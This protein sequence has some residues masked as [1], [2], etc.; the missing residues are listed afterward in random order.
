MLTVQLTKEELRTLITILEEYL[1]DLRMEIADTDSSDFKEKLKR[2][3]QKVTEILQKLQ[4]RLI[5]AT[6]E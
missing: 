5:A 3:K 2:E 6:E 1:S 4:D